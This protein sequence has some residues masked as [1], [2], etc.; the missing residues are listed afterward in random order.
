[1]GE[2]RPDL[3]GQVALCPVGTADGRVHR[4]GRRQGPALGVVH[5]L[6]DHVPQR[7]AHYQAWPLG[8]AGDVLAY[9]EMPA[10]LADPARGS[11]PAASL[12]E[13]GGHFLPAFPALRR[14]TS[15]WYFTPLPL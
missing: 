7:T 12:Q 4:R 13:R 3:A 1:V 11:V 15:P 2:Q 6:G 5:D 14:M 10:C 8:G 9:P